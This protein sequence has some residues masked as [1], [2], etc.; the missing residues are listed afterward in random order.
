MQYLASWLKDGR[1][2][3][4]FVH[5]DDV[6]LDDLLGQDEIK[7]RFDYPLNNPAVFEL[8]VLS[9]SRHSSRS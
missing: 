7:V 9:P 6:N 8:P 3:S 4:K 5:L 1:L 2:R